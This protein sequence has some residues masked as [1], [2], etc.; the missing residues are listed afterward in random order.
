MAY[1]SFYRGLKDNYNYT[2]HQDS[3]YFATDTQEIILNDISYGG[4]IISNVEFNDG[5]IIITFINGTSKEV[6]IPEATSTNS[7][8]LSAEDKT[9]IDKML[10]DEDGSLSDLIA[11]LEEK[12]D[13]FIDSKNQPGG[14]VGLDESGLISSDIL[15]SYVDDVIDVYAVYGQDEIGNLLSINL[16]EDS[17]HQIP[18]TGETGKIYV[19]VTE[20]NPGFQF[21]WSGTTFIQ[22]SSGG[23]ILGSITGT[24]YDGA[25]GY[26]NEL[27]I[28]SLPSK[29]ITN[30]IDVTV[31]T[32]NAV[33]TISD[34]VKDDDTNVY[35][36]GD[37]LQITIPAATS[38]S[39][40][41]IT[42]E[43]K[44][45]I[46][47]LQEQFGNVDQLDILLKSNAGVGIISEYNSGEFFGD[48][49]AGDTITEAIQKIENKIE[50]VI[51]GS[52]SSIA[53]LE[54]E[55]SELKEDIGNPTE[56]SVS[57]TGLYLD[58]EELESRVT[59]NEANIQIINGDSETEGSIDYKV[60]I[61]LDWYEA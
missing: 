55:I 45:Y 11:E 10:G 42:A 26:A 4:G 49:E 20:D 47:A 8:L 44:K 48:V 40:G 61:A 27:A 59:T 28:Q 37:N 43:D 6:E 54:K 30:I 18:I 12:L 36:A 13:E 57:A 15:P 39:S 7:G 29:I 35:T 25:K 23:L 1:V 56:G 34:S 60:S 58:I 31:S 2:S 17:D 19:D 38:T 46:D 3:I 53:D 33:I 21:R 51:D 32:E 9:K 41:V 24:A 5:K 52:D 22:I 16:Y 50:N 14:Y